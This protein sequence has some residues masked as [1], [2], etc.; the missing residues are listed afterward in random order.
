MRHMQFTEQKQQALHYERFH[1]PRPR[2]QQK[3]SG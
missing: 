1:P 3:C 2:V